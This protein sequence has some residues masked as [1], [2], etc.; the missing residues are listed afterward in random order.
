M[1][2]ENEIHAILQESEVNDEDYLE[3]ANE[4]WRAF[5][6]CC[7]Q[8]YVTGLRP[9][10]VLL[11][12]SVSGIVLLKRKMYSFLRPL[13]FVEHL[14]LCTDYISNNHLIELEDIFNCEYLLVK[15]WVM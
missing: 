14:I 6:S 1:A 8:Y 15:N 10:G 12:P 2:V 4:C 5:Y 13:D 11:L 3:C 7:I 9:L